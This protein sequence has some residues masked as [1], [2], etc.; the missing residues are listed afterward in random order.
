MGDSFSHLWEKVALAKQGSDEG[1]SHFNSPSPC[2]TF[3]LNSSPRKFPRA[4]R[5]RRRRICAARHRRAGR[6][7]APL[8]GRGELCDAAPARAAYRRPARPPAGH[9]RGEKGPARRRAR[10]GDPGLS[11]KRRARLARSG[12]DPEGRQEGRVLRRRD[13]ASG[14][15][16]HRPARRDHPRRHQKLPLAEIH[17]LGRGLA[18][19]PTRC[20][21]CGRCTPFSRPSAPRPRRRTVVRF[22][23]TASSRARAPTATASWRRRTIA[24]AA[25]RRLCPGARAR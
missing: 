18:S 20:A 1:P 12:D 13:R 2:P 15:R 3:C 21:G 25:L 17:A 9:A 4:C 7:R 22:A 6:A 8:R 10:G 14:R 19:A 11:Q 24:G 23:S 5:R 16:D